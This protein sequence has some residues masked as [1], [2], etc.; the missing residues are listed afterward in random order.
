MFFLLYLP[1]DRAWT[2]V[3]HNRHWLTKV[4]GYSPENP[5]LGTVDY[6]NASWGEVSALA[7][8][9]E[10][11]EQQIEFYCYFSRLLNTQSEYIWGMW[12]AVWLFL[13]TYALKANATWQLSSA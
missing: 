11:C 12:A 6:W 1:E 3:R 13:W 10:Y 9:S 5:F 4:T 2:I 8:A 7:N